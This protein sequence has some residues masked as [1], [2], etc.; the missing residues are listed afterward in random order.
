MCTWSCPLE[1]L[2]SFFVLLLT[3]GGILTLAQCEVLKAELR[4]KDD[5]LKAKD[6]MLKAKDDM[7]KAKDDMIKELQDKVRP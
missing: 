2:K 7:L 1:A 3:D 6:D 4:G 5:M